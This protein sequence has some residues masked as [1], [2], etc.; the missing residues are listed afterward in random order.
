MFACV[1]ICSYCLPFSLHLCVFIYN[2]DMLFPPAWRVLQSKPLQSKV[3][4]RPNHRS[5]Y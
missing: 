3:A 4:F 2:L 1:N 5:G